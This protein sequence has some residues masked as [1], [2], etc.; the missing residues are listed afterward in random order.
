MKL[1]LRTL[2]LL[3]VLLPAAAHATGFTDVGQDIAS[4]KGT[5]VELD[6]YMRVRGEVL[7]NLDLD[8]G[9]TPSGQPLFPVPVGDPSGQSLTYADMRLR[10]DLAVYAPGGGIAVK[11][12]SDI[13][14]NQPLGGSYAGIP[15]AS[16]TQLSPTSAIRVKRAY[17]EALTP[18]GVITAG[19]TG[20]QWGLGMLANGGDCMDCDSGDAAD[21]VA[22]ITP[23]AGHI[24]ALAYDFSAI[25]PF[26]PRTDNTRSVVIEP[27]ADVHTVTFAMLHWRDDFSRKRRSAA[28]KS[29]F[30]Y[31]A[32]LSHRWQNNDVP[33]AYLPTASPVAI[34]ASQVMQRGF[35]ATAFDVWTRFTHPWIR[36]EMEAA[37]LVGRVDQPSLIPGVL[38]HDAVTSTQYGGALES[39]IAE[40]GSRFG[41]GLD[42]GLASG[43]DSPG[44]GAFPKVGAPAAKPGDLDGPKANPPSHTTVNNFRFHPDYRVDQILFREIIGT[45]TG[46][47]YLRPHARYHLY[48]S[49]AG[50][51]SAQVAAIGSQAMFAAEAPG[52]KTPLGV[53][54]DPSLSY[55][56]RDGFLLAFD[57]G[58]LIPMAGLDNPQQH[59]NARAAQIARTRIM[60]RF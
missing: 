7:N 11:V 20:N 30:E 16:S 3:I 4:H 27:S 12:R 9:L 1:G 22:L 50:T 52:G 15:S 42:A 29:T 34:D 54:I 21:R 14:D 53:E 45:V 25:G 18:I 46:A 43:D 41:A 24:F 37:V 38:Y 39:E 23:M 48:R 56:S 44:F 36:V 2:P 60:Y 31:G 26:V 33:A 28:D 57:Y 49:A 10:T 6:G 8:R 35:Q 59:L 13:L 40:P 58:V 32:Y 19:R 5:P 47:M 51:L 55:A 17:G